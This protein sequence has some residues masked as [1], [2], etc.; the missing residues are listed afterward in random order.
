MILCHLLISQEL[1]E[2]VEADAYLPLGIVCSRSDRPGF[3]DP[4][5]AT[6]GQV[7][8]YSVM[9]RAANSP[10]RVKEKR[11]RAAATIA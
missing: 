5:E 2:V 3:G 4:T 8:Q 10:F 9:A 7:P 11:E 1:V 6:N